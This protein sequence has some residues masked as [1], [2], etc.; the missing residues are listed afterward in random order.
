MIV[1]E[2][3]LAS[4]AVV[5]R[6]Q[7]EI[8]VVLE[9]EFAILSTNVAVC[10]ELDRATSA[11]DEEKTLPGSPACSTFGPD[12]HAVNHGWSD[13]SL[14]TVLKCMFVCVKIKIHMLICMYVYHKKKT[15]C[16]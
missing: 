7:L 15:W 3:V 10:A 8:C 4:I 16:C 13:E 12:V 14:R 2:P 9:S 6:Q 11:L 5:Y 1:C